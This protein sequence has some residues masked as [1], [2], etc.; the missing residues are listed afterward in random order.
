MTDPLILKHGAT[1]SGTRSTLG[2]TAVI[3]CGVAGAWQLG[4]HNYPWGVRLIV[5]AIVGFDVFRNATGVIVDM[6]KRAV[7]SYWTLLGLRIGSWVALSEF[8]GLI[9]MKINLRWHH[10]GGNNL[11]GLGAR[12]DQEAK[13]YKVVLLHEKKKDVTLTE[14]SAHHQG[15]ESGL[16]LAELLGMP[17]EDRVKRAMESAKARRK[18]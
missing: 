17:F 8:S 1:F 7:K 14:S 9:L 2:I 11:W 16:E 10:T 3:V 6:E 5:L 18:R 12:Q 15:I 4:L 13:F